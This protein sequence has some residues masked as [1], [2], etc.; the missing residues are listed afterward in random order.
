MYPFRK[1]NKL[2]TKD[3]QLKQKTLLVDIVVTYNPL[4]LSSLFTALEEP[5]FD[6]LE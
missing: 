2:I 5:I 6:L 3:S 4:N 1:I